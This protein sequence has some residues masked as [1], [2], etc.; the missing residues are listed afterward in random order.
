MA[1]QIADA[2]HWARINRDWEASGLTQ[3]EFC[4]V[5]GLSLGSFRYWRYKPD[6][7]NGLER[8][9]Q[10][11]DGLGRPLRDGARPRFVPVTL[12]AAVPPEVAIAPRPIEI[13]L[14][15]GQRVAVGPGFDSQT[16]QQVVA[17][18]EDR[19]C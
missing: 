11:T 8:L 3:V 19:P 16:L 1:M 6:R 17:A 9:D 5:R 18:L 7:S 12:T 2:A 10:A 14:A 13:L 4:R 15:A